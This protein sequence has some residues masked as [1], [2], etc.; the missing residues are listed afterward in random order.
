M[1]SPNFVSRS[2]KRVKVR[3]MTEIH[4][5]IESMIA[6]YAMGAVPEDEVPAIRAHILSCETCFA[7]AESY[8]EAL[9]ALATSVEPVPLPKGFAERVLTEA[10][11][12][13]PAP[14]TREGARNR[15][16]RRFL[17]PGL[18]VLAAIS[19]FGTTL[20]LVGSLERQDEYERV[21]ASL[22]R[23]PD[24]LSLD[25][26]GGAQGVVAS[27][28]EGSVLVAVDLGAAPRG[29]DYQLWLI[30]DGVPVP[31]VTFDVT[32]S[33]VVVESKFDL[34]DYEGAAITV[35]PEGGS[36]QPTTDPV[37]SS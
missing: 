36:Q 26:P 2:P 35:E 34:S 4:D 19:L 15:T 31:D 24:A 37:L 30:E 21:V 16:W 32:G 22:V 33:V 11:G 17:V 1:G 6:A 8:T 23:D 13:S 25:G 7:E 14:V 12:E 29:R 3:T 18:A 28:K 27:G 5:R 9:A 20:A 10:R